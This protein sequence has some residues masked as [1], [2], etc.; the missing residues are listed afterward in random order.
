MIDFNFYF[1]FYKFFIISSNYWIK[2]NLDD[3]GDK[4]RE[5]LNDFWEFVATGERGERRAVAGLGDFERFWSFRIE[6]LIGYTFESSKIIP[7]SSFN[8]FPLMVIFMFFLT[9]F[10][11]FWS[12][13]TFIICLFL[14]FGEC[15]IVKRF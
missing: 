10:L 1:D 11:L 6:E 3:F 4:I 14:P 8:Y 7:L 2:G 15:D 9:F 5:F 12:S 13:E